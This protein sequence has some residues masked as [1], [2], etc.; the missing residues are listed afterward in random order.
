MIFFDKI[1]KK[2]KVGLR[3]ID[4]TIKF[5]RSWGKQI[6]LLV[7]SLSEKE[8]N[9][10]LNICKI[11]D[12]HLEHHYKFWRKNEIAKSNMK[13]DPILL[14]KSQFEL[15]MI[16]WVLLTQKFK[17][18]EIREEF[19]Q[20][21]WWVI[22]YSVNIYSSAL[23]NN[24]TYKTYNEA[25][26]NR[27]ELY[28][29]IVSSYFG[30]NRDYSKETAFQNLYTLLIA[31]PLTNNISNL[32]DEMIGI[33]LEVQFLSFNGFDNTVNAITFIN[34]FQKGINTFSEKIDQVIQK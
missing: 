24:S 14:Y 28:F 27:Q 29:E 3:I 22:H 32:K 4:D 16:D 15:L 30:Y 1:F 34:S 26:A 17:K 18:N 12:K 19:G 8:L 9:Q 21:L 11:I 6:N 31:Y 33:K 7:Q 10:L 2:K 23:F 25:F 13:A 5:P 20:T